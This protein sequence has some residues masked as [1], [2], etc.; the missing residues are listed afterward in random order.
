MIKKLLSL[1]AVAA[2]SLTASANVNLLSSFGTNGWG[3]SYDAETQ[4]V[5]YEAGKGAW[6]GIGQWLGGADYSA[7]SSLVIEFAEPLEESAQ[8]IIEYADKT[9]SSGWAN[10]GASSVEA[11]INAE[12]AV[13]V[14]QYY[15]QNSVDGQVI[16]IKDVYLVDPT[17]AGEE[18][19]LFEGEQATDWYPGLTISKDKIIAAGANATLTIDVTVNAGKDG[20]SYK[21][22]TGWTGVVL[23]SFELVEGYSSEYNTVWTTA[24]EVKYVVTADDIAALQANG[25]SDF[26]IT[27]GDAVINKVTI[28]SAVEDNN[29][30]TSVRSLSVD[31]N[32]PVEVY[33][34]NGVRVNGDNL[35]A[36]LYIRR[37]GQS[38]SKILVK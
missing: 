6:Q 37:Q 14:N 25:D 12:S 13:S 34:L 32:A 5:T 33:N 28:A 4:T 3:G 8:L 17:P 24:T 26:H 19:V 18:V 31:D 38:V 7:Y 21:L 22:S 1:A 11:A 30:T 27:G 10:A 9:N 2:M 16:K 23:P 35:P 36:G 15:L 20:W 29:E